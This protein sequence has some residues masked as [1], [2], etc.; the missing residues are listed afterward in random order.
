MQVKNWVDCDQEN[1]MRAPSTGNSPVP[2]T[3]LYQ[4]IL[5]RI[6]AGITNLLAITDHQLAGRD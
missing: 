2:Q 1:G 3:H 4:R 6:Q 5:A